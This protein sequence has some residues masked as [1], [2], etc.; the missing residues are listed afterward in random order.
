MAGRL[1]HLDRGNGIIGFMNARI[2]NFGMH[3]LS[4]RV[5]LLSVLGSLVCQPG[6]AASDLAP[7]ASA[8]LFELFETVFYSNAGLLSIG[9]L[10]KQ[11]ADALSAPFVNLTEG[12]KALS[13]CCDCNSRG[14]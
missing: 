14:Q 5:V 2:K 12:L 8:A 6:L 11:D 4:R 7:R 9:K 13:D 1:D 10:S 3:G